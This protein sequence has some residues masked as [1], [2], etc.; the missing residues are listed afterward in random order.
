MKS[1]RTGRVETDINAPIEK[2]WTLLSHLERMGEWSPECY[3]VRWERDWSPPASVGARL[4]GWNRYGLL[5]WS[6]ACRVETVLPLRELS[7][8]TLVRE[9][10][11]TTWSFRLSE[12]T[13]GVALSESF[14]VHWLPPSARLAEDY[15]MRDRDR[16]RLEAMRTTLARIKQFAE[17]EWS[18]T[19]PI[20]S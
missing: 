16:R 10:K 13:D 1:A 9:K 15:L 4:R 3:R 20:A 8:C 2:V 7:F 17:A 18:S 5:R 6:V 11:M 19:E 12:S 14:E